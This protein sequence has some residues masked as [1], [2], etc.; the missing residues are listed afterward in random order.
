MSVVLML[1]VGII[2]IVAVGVTIAGWYLIK[3]I[4]RIEH[5]FVTRDEF[6]DLARSKKRKTTTR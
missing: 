6:N 4:S 3:E 2:W 5:E 1:T